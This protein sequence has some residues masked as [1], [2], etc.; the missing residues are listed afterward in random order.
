MSVGD[1]AITPRISPVAVWYSRASVSSP[2]ACESSFVSSSILQF[3][4]ATLSR[5]E[6]VMATRASTSFFPQ[7]P[8]RYRAGLRERAPGTLATRQRASGLSPKPI[9]HHVATRWIDGRTLVGT[10]SGVPKW[11]GWEHAH[12]EIAAQDPH[13]R[14]SFASVRD[15]P[16]LENLRAD[17]EFYRPP[18]AGIDGNYVE[19]G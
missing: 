15:R 9:V 5:D 2:L 14:P 4:Y 1:A 13:C 6:A 12:V 10:L 16:S 3:R 18:H 11:R 7:S 17:K 8:Q 19:V